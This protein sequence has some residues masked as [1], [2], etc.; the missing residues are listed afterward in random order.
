MIIDYVELL[1]DVSDNFPSEIWQQ[2]SSNI[3]EKNAKYNRALHEKSFIIIMAYKKN[4]VIVISF[5]L[6]KR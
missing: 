5:I 1:S 6:F 4:L 3:K 2:K